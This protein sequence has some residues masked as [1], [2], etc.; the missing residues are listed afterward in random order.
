M[1]KFFII[2]FIT[3]IIVGSILVYSIFHSVISIANKAKINSEYLKT[4]VGHQYVIDKDTLTVVN[5][6][7]VKMTLT[8]S[9]STEVDYNLID[10]L[11]PIK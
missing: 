5:Y 6:S 2:A 7:T 3:M 9:N 11:E 10:K 4:Y 1:N 8:M